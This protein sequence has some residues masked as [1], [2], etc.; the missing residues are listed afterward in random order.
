MY[1]FE[2]LVD[3]MANT[4]YGFYSFC[5]IAA[6]GIW[7]TISLWNDHDL[8]TGVSLFW[9]FGLVL[10]TGIIYSESFKPATVYANEQVVGTLV[11]FQPEGYN[12][13]SGKSRA[14]RH[15]MYVVYE[16][17]G[18]HVIMNAKTGVDY[19]KRAVMYKN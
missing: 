10:F 15:Y 9:I 6:L 19:P 4:H 1:S 7:A 11:G 17:N 2:P 14:D 18:Q 13:K 8:D 16:V 5:V 12:E 3:T